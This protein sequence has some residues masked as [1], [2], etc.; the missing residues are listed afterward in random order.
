M[1]KAG[2]LLA[3]LPLLSALGGCATNPVTGREELSLVPESTELEIGREQYLP[4]RQM[5]GGDYT[6]RPELVRYVQ[7]VGKK[8][9]AVSDRQLPYEFVVVNDATPNAW[10]LP[11]GK[12]AVNRGL[13]L[14]LDSEAELAAV[15]G[16]EIVHAAARHTAKSIER[17]MLLQGALAGAA[18]ASGSSEYGGLALGAAALGA[19][20]ISQRYSR[21]AELEADHYGMIYMKRAGYDPEAAVTLQQTF[22][23]LA[24]GRDQNWLEGLFATHPPSEE[25]VRKNRELAAKLG[26]G[27]RLGKEEYQRRIAGLKHDRKA[28]AYYEQGQKVLKKSPEKALALAGLAIEI[29]PREPLFWGLK[30]D[31]LAARNRDQEARRAYDKALALDSGFYR[32]YLKRGELAAKMG[33]RPQA[34]RDLKRSMELLPTAEASYDLGLI[35][36]RSGDEQAALG[37]LRQAAEAGGT[38]GKAAGRELAQL[39]LERNPGHY[40]QTGLGYDRYGNLL[41][42]VKNPTSLAVKDIVVQVGRRDASGRIYRGITETLPGVL[43][44]GQQAQ[45]RTR[46]TGVTRERRLRKYGARVVRARLAR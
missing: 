29:Q 42:V 39:D 3:L 18:I 44:P 8:L 22:V 27:G 20:L 34:Q 37:Y 45:I 9:A 32:Y 46:I 2:L 33:D 5:Q 43:R 10:A 14:E 16:H 15:L 7:R 19:K 13:L 31:A 6:A 4:T 30:G 24:K 12:I 38:T 40:L 21:E 36:K 35:A 25:R 23:R 28:Y 11:G 26:T 41:L 17:G 1:N